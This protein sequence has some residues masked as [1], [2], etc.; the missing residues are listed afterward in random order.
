[1]YTSG[2]GTRVLNLNRIGRAYVSF[3]SIASF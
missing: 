1:L 2:L 3:G